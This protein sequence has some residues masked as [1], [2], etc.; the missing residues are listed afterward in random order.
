MPG[1]PILDFTRSA[2]KERDTRAIK[3]N[4]GSHLWQCA[5]ASHIPDGGWTFLLPDSRRLSGI[6]F[7][8]RHH[9]IDAVT[10][11]VRARLGDNGTPATSRHH[12][13]CGIRSVGRSSNESQGVAVIRYLGRDLDTIWRV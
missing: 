5:A 1:I 10:R 9:G 3:A 11:L 8:V 7:S 4:S 12:A 6:D 13:R 2:S